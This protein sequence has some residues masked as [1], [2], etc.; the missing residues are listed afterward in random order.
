M[1]R[2]FFD[3]LRWTFQRHANRSIERTKDGMMRTAGVQ[4]CV[5]HRLQTIDLQMRSIGRDDL[6]VQCPRDPRRGK[7]ID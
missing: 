4:A 5:I 7:R 1:S 6:L 3:H 2:C